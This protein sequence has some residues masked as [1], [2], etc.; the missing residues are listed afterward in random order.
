FAGESSDSPPAGSSSSGSVP[1][2]DASIPE[3][4]SEASRPDGAALEPCVK[5]SPFASDFADGKSPD[6][7]E[8]IDDGSVNLMRSAMGG[9]TKDGSLHFT[10]A[11]SAAPH[12]HILA[13]GLSPL[14]AR[15]FELAV[16]IALRSLKERVLVFAELRFKNRNLLGLAIDPDHRVIIGQQDLDL[17]MFDELAGTD[18][19]PN[20]AWSHLLLRLEQTAEGMVVSGAINGTAMTRNTRP[21]LPFDVVDTLEIGVSYA[22]PDGEGDF[23]LDRVGLLE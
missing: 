6:W 2:Q 17:E 20:D 15:C 23:Q 10:Y 3:A 4:S 7:Q 11:K 1:G 16:D 8:S 21:L 18:P 12:H 9:E 19:V 13:H 5:V 14:N 22:A